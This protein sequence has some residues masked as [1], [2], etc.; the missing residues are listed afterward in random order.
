MDLRR[1]APGQAARLRRGLA[2]AALAAAVAAVAAPACERRTVPVSRVP[3]GPEDAGADAGG[4]AV[5]A[6]A[7][8]SPAA[9]QEIPVG[10]L[11][12]EVRDSANGELMPARLTLIGVDGSPNP[13]LSK[14]D[15]PRQ[16]GRAIAAY[17]LV[18][19][20]SGQGAVDVPRGTYDVFVSRGPEWELS[21]TRGVEI[22]PQ[23][24]SV[25]ASLAHVVD[26]RGWLSAD[27]HVHAAESFDSDVP[28]SARVHELVADG[29]EMIVSTDHNVITD[30]APEIARLHAGAYLASARGE[31]ITTASSGHFGAFPLRILR[32]APGNGAI[33]IDGRT[34]AQI[35]RAVRKA[36]P[37]ALIQVNHPRFPR[38]MGYF[39]EGGLDAAE[40]RATA[41]G[42]SFDFDAV[43]VMN[44]L[45]AA[46]PDGLEEVLKDW[47]GLLS[48]GRMIAATGN[49]D[50][51]HLDINLGGYPRN[52]VRLADDSPVNVKPAEVARAVKGMRSF[53]TTAP[54]VQLSVGSASLGD[55]A[56]APGG[57]VRGE[58]AVQ[59]AP[60]V[61]VTTV[62]LYLDGVEARRWSVLEGTEPARF[63]G[64][65]DLSI[66]RDGFL[67][68]R[69]EGDRPLAPVIGNDQGFRVRPFALTNPVLLDVDGDGK[70][71]PARGPGGRAARK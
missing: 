65:F 6:P 3:L 34:P 11:D 18:M 26:S 23:G 36:A 33:P 57:K 14:G 7:A 59:A 58:I 62:I 66:E 48:R 39:T 61:S 50:T 68:A 53:F 25:R 1:V 10:R 30:Y 44:G 64:D 24:A 29:V 9:G 47:F 45:V 22:G 12:Y 38:G 52:F 5:S 20:L 56:P 8:S 69:V 2:P 71:T 60:W 35:F 13:E 63:R 28:M 42:F 21:V 27:F 17:N 49:S 54:F 16:E 55:V 4:A 43:E 32:A 15:I 37:G 70:Y 40:D 46:E 51:H 41:K 19:S 67:V 31:E